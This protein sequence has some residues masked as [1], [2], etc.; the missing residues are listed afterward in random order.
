MLIFK[1]YL[2]PQAGRRSFATFERVTVTNPIV[3]INGD[4]MAA[5][6][7]SRVKDSLVT[8]YVDLKCEQ[9]DLSI[10][11]RDYTDDKVTLDALESIKKH[12]VA[13]KCST[14]TATFSRM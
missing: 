7:W 13:I 3:E 12:R 14:I 1:R 8:P 5:V 6:I 4:E 11:N 10:Q 9:H 2:A